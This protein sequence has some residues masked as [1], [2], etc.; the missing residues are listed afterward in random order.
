MAY[1]NWDKPFYVDPSTGESVAPGTLGAIPVPTYGHYVGG[2]GYSAAVFGGVLIVQ[3]NGS[4]YS[5][6]DELNANGTDEQDAVDIIDYHA[7][8]HD[9]RSSLTGPVYTALQAQADAALLGSVVALDSHYDP[10][11][12]LMAGVISFGM[13]GSLALH[14]YLNVLSPF[15]LIGA[16][17]DAVRD[18]DYGLDNLPPGELAD[19]LNFIF[20]PTGDPNVFVFDFAIRTTSFRQEFV[21]VIVM[22]TLNA[23]IDGGEADNVPLS[24]GFPFPGTSDYHLAYNAVTGDIDLNAG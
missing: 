20:E 9:V 19:A 12:A 3:G 13:V 6:M 10:E 22:N 4:P 17:T 15:Q 14:G 11:A 2:F 23:I 18:I 21:E 16:L 7:Y 1:I 8:V 24:T 5:S